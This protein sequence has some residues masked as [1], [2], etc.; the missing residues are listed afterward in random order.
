MGELI[1]IRETHRLIV[2]IFA[3]DPALAVELEAVGALVEPV[4]LG[5]RRVAGNGYTSAWQPRAVL[6]AL[7]L[8]G[9][10]CCAEKTRPFSEWLSQRRASK[11]SKLC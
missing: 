7:D 4:K 5:R 9:S 8:K 3:L 11:A 1:W 10:P 6:C 2:I